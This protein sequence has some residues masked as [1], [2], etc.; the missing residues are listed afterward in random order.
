MEEPST[1]RWRRRLRMLRDV[2]ATAPARLR[3]GYLA[4][5]VLGTA[6]ISAQPVT[7]KWIVDGVSTHDQSL[8][9]TGVLLAALTALVGECGGRSLAGLLIYFNGAGG[10]EVSVRTLRAIARLPS[11]EHLERPEHHD[12]IRLVAGQGAEVVGAL[13]NIVGTIR[14]LAQLTISIVLLMT[15]DPLLGLFPLGVLPSVGLIPR[16]H[17]LRVAAREAAAEHERAAAHL[18]AQFTDPDAAMELRVFGA[19]AA[20][21]GEAD[22]RWRA[23]VSARARGEASAVVLTS[24]GLAVL[25][26]GY[27]GALAI[28]AWRAHGDITAAG[29]AV[30]VI[31]LAGSLRW[32]LLD[33]VN[34]GQQLRSA[35]ELI[36]RVAWLEDYR[37]TGFSD[38][39]GTVDVP[40][41]LTS[42][43]R[44][45]G[46]SFRYPGTDTDVLRDVDLEL[47]A[48]SVVA[49]VGANGA[50]KTTL[51]KLLCGFYRPT[52]GTI[53]A[54]GADLTGFAATEWQSRVSAAF[55]DY[56]RLEDQFRHS[57]APFIDGIQTLDDDIER[58]AASGDALTLTRDWPDGL[59]THLGK[60]YQDGEQLSGG[61]WQRVAVARA[62]YR[63]QPLLLILDEPTAALDPAAEHRLYEHYS[64]AARAARHRNGCI[65]VL[66]SHRFSTVR[67]AD[68][69]IVLDAGSVAEQGS[70]DELMQADGQYAHLF[71]QQA[72]AYS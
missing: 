14:T 33:S 13:T 45:D 47:P 49:L 62:M 3:W 7:L 27:V 60:S 41:G 69:I 66:I 65:T 9:V 54:D 10:H 38:S 63:A 1:S 35:V 46:V 19:V 71:S 50:G 20:F 39:T 51:I 8:A 2:A 40:V 16:I 15:V 23:A 29:N 67:M 56:L 11:L 61:Q 18:H 53:S 48:G 43:I 58:A 36:D 57:I 52:A 5:S 21:D 59:A 72:A 31:S 22:R 64:A 6:A 24:L 32:Q 17:K 26:A 70:H 30:M 25:A 4:G 44:L 55:Q 42:G 37:P 28:V 12:K 68:R 34:I